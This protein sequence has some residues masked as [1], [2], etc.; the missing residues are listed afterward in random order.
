M[1]KL[2]YERTV[3]TEVKVHVADLLSR[4]SVLRSSVAAPILLPNSYNSGDALITLGT[5]LN[6][7]QVQCCLI[8]SSFENFDVVFPG[9]EEVV[10]QCRGLFVHNGAMSGRVVV[11]PPAGVESV[12]LQYIWS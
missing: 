5:P 7:P 8:L 2:P 4:T 9:A 6:I 11:R 3:V 1:K 10:L 12:R